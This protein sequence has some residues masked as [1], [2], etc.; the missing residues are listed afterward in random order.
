M[1]NGSRSVG[2]QGGFGIIRI[3]F[4]PLFGRFFHYFFKFNSR[5]VVVE[6]AVHLGAHSQLAHECHLELVSLLAVEHLGVLSSRPSA[7]YPSCE[8]PQ[9]AGAVVGGRALGSAGESPFQS[10]V[11]SP[12]STAMTQTPRLIRES[13]LTSRPCVPTMRMGTGMGWRAIL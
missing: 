12:A 13:L 8:A 2:V 4:P 6:D 3:M 10:V 7:A 1:A 9:R 5:L 11:S